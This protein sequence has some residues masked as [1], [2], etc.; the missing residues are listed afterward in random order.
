MRSRAMRLRF[1]PALAA[2]AL[3]L[4]LPVALPPDDAMAPAALAGLDPTQLAAALC[5]PRRSPMN[6]TQ[7]LLAA[8]AVAQPLSAASG[9]GFYPD[10]ARS[11][12]PLTTRSQE[13]RLW[14][15]Q[16]LMLT[17]GFSHAGAVA[18]F[19][20]AQAADPACALCWWGEA[21]ALG[22]NI[23]A[24]MDGRDR[25]AALAALG[26]ALVLADGASPMEQ[27]L[28]RALAA[29]YSRDEA[30]DRAA[31]DVAYADAMLAV[32]AAFP[33]DDDVAVLAAEAV[34]DT[35]PW[36]YWLADGKPVGKS[37]E[38]VRLLEQ[39]RARNA[40]HAQANHLYVHMMEAVDPAR[41]DAAA[42]R[43]A[44]A[45]VRSN[46]HL[47][48]MPAHIW[49]RRGR[50]RDSIAANVAAVR[51][52]EQWIAAT[53]DQ[54]MLR[55]GYYPHN[56]HFIVT[57]AMM[58][59]DVATA[60]REAMRLG[61]L[62]NADLSAQLPAA[63]AVEAAPYQ[64][65]A[66]V[67]TP[68][69]LLAMPAPDARLPY[70]L[71]MRHF[72]RAVAF[73]HRR[74]KAGFDAELRAMAAQKDHPGTKD[75]VAQAVPLPDLIRIADHVARGRWAMATG[76]YKVAAGHFAAAARI[77]TTIPYMEPSY[78]HYPVGQSLGAARLLAGDAA[79]ASEAF[80][81]ALAQ[82]P[83]NG[84]ALFGLAQSEK[85]QG[86]KPEAAA[87]ATAFARAWAGDP[88]WLKLDRL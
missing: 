80:R 70:A 21:M 59:G 32:A 62:L 39:V 33:A 36:N 42:D 69:A 77:E 87:A 38:A 8:A 66:M 37:G 43:L 23:N 74:D 56:V 60:R 85:A 52:D 1:G 5:D 64:V 49:H 40:N 58:A 45:G 68:E 55:Y 29:R 63:Q 14:F 24:P 54:G 65:M 50:Y 35:S 7:A 75:L 83:G 3:S 79:G 26:K 4:A 46:G 20:K 22:P 9:I 34:M 48:H 25:G 73:A 72:A 88:K 76:R 10:L 30:A 53:N 17:Y 61:T 13:A 41:A 2:L 16:G 11:T 86:H 51:A 31:L 47:I 78:W 81:A 6:P 84:W 82:T 44:A 19:R 27:A 57:S 71:A 67:A 18:S 28:I 15:A 12:F